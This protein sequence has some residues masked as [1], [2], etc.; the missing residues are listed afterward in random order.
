MTAAGPPRRTYTQNVLWFWLGLLAFAAIG[1]AGYFAG[2]A[3][4]GGNPWLIAGAVVMLA[5]NAGLGVY[6]IRRGNI[7]LGSG[8]FVGYALAT[9]MSG[10]ECTLWQ[11]SSGSYGFLGGFISYLI[12]LGG[13]IIVM[14]V[15]AIGEAIYR[16][17]RGG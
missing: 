7:P 6:A 8:M 10:G 15:V 3:V 13:G 16:S 12:V 9:V 4:G 17:R 14:L 11:G 5:L 1:V 2:A